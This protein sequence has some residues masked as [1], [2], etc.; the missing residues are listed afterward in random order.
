MYKTISYNIKRKLYFTK[1]YE[2]QIQ[3]IVDIIV[4]YYMRTSVDWTF[5]HFNIANFLEGRN[6][7]SQ[8]SSS[9]FWSKGLSRN[10]LRDLIYRAAVSLA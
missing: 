7:L 5:H 10:G 3:K 6:A 9:I 1:Y 2:Y 8:V 4:G